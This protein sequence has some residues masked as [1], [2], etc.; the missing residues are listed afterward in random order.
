[1]VLVAAPRP[2]AAHPLGALSDAEQTRLRAYLLSGGNML[3]AIGAEAREAAPGYSKVV[4][5]FGIALDDLLV[6][7]GEPTLAFPN[8]RGDTFVAIPKASVITTGL[9]PSDDARDVPQVVVDVARSLRR[10]ASGATLTDLLGTSDR[11]FA[12]NEERASE[13]ARAASLDIPDKRGNDR[14]GP[15]VL[16]MASEGTKATKDAPHGPRVVVVGSAYAF[17][18]SNFREP[19]PWHGTAFLMG[20]AIAWLAAKP[21]LLDVPDK[22]SVGAGLRMTEGGESEVRRY[23]LFFM[24]ITAIVLGVLVALR[25]RSTENKKRTRE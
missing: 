17:G 23:V 8:A 15:F 1:M 18:A 7:E 25:R 24:P 11:A 4:E 10:V 14:S 12:V 5:P 9:V 16:A 3:L 2:Q 21:A 19:L 22:P 6:I 13:I 20:N